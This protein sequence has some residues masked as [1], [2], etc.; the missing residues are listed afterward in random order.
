MADPV[1][2]RWLTPH[3]QRIWRS[4]TAATMELQA[5]LDRQLRTDAGMPVAYY[6][7]LVMLSESPGRALRMT[8]LAELCNSS[9]SRLSHAV[10]AL[11]KAGWVTRCGIAGDRRG[12]MAQLTDAGYAALAEAAPGHVEEVR[13]CL[14]DALTPE[15]LDALHEITQAVRSAVQRR[16]AE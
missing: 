14:V 10:S 2:T 7:I 4:Y 9:R 5:H 1:Q 6:E 3:E 12:A 13:A 8:R 11:E 16:A 15:Q